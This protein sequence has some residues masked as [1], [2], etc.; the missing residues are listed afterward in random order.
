MSIL[1]AL[2]AIVAGFVAV[3]YWVAAIVAGISAIVAI[4]SSKKG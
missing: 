2:L 3:K 1:L 4:V